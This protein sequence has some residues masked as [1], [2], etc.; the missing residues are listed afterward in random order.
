MD[1]FEIYQLNVKVIWTST[2]TFV[3]NFFGKVNISFIYVVVNSVFSL[4]ICMMI[5]YLLTETSGNVSGQQSGLFSLASVNKCK[6]FQ[7]RLNVPETTLFQFAYATFFQ[8]RFSITK[9]VVSPL[10]K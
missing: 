1:V 3:Y 8:R 6:L 10:N 7:L 9:C 5:E 2:S 4:K